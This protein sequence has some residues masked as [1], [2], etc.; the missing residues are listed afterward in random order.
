MIKGWYMG[1]DDKT[2]VIAEIKKNNIS[3][4]VISDK[5]FK[6]REMIDIRTF[7]INDEGEYNPSTKGITLNHELFPEF[8]LAINELYEK[9]YK[10]I[11]DKSDDNDLQNII[12]NI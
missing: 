6:Q 12:D 2:T 1:T 11:G 10:S 5:V 7:F 4:I 8:A 3:K 9:N